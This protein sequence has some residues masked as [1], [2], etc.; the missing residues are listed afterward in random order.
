MMA[1]AMGISAAPVLHPSYSRSA[2]TVRSAGSGQLLR[3]SSKNARMRRRASRAD[4]SW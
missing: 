3:C 1:V 2:V 4:G